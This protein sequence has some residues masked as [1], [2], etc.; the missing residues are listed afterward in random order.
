MIIQLVVVQNL[1]PGRD[2]IPLAIRLILSAQT[3]SEPK[4]KIP[5]LSQSRP[6]DKKYRNGLMRT[7]A[8]LEKRYHSAISIVVAPSICFRSPSSSTEKK[9][10]RADAVKL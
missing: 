10:S 2:V 1:Q 8:R 7:V 3:A 4:R 9:T 5:K 6:D